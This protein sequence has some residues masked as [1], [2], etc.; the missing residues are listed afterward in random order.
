MVNYYSDSEEYDRIVSDLNIEK[1]R[2]ERDLYIAQTRQAEAEVLST[3]TIT[4]QAG[5]VSDSL[6]VSAEELGQFAFYFPVIGEYT[7]PFMQRLD[8]WSRNN[9]DKSLCITFNSPGGSIFDGFAL[10]DFITELKRRGHHVIT[11]CVGAAMSMGAVLLQAGDERVISSNA[12][13]LIHEVQMHSAEG[14]TSGANMKDNLEFQEKI[15]KIVLKQLAKK[16]KLSEQD[17]VKK[18][19][20]YDWMMDAKEALKFGF[21][22]RIEE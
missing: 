19:K 6:G 3:T 12:F 1:I 16:S 13:F 17:I 9:P 8:S 22:D 11:K 5:R 15:Q 10:Y 18:W 2:A 7:A 4:K 20:K 21:V 14:F